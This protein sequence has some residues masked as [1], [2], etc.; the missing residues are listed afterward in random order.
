MKQTELS[1][2]C[3]ELSGM[4][5]DLPELFCRM[6]CRRLEAAGYSAWDKAGP[7]NLAFS[8]RKAE[9]EVLD[10]CH[11]DTVPEK[12]YMMLC[13]RACGQY[14]YALKQSGKLELGGVDL[15][16]ILT[17]LS[18]GDVKVDFDKGAS[19]EAR[20]DALL[21]KM[22]NAGKDQLQCYRRVRF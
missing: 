10:Y 17:S 16:G 13:D 12:L 6:V 14:L 21:E 11:I 15:S 20:L 8:I 5:S 22:M 9:T 4:G 3:A 18:E 2:V 19:D 7:F 1:E